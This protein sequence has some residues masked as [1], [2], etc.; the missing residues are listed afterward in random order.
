MN[1]ATSRLN[2]K[3]ML[4][5][6]VGIVSLIGSCAPLGTAAW[7]TWQGN[8]SR[9]L[10]LAAD[11]PLVGVAVDVQAARHA[12]IALRVDL[13]ALDQATVKDT[14]AVPVTVRVRDA[15]GRVL[16]E[17][18]RDTEA[19]GARDGHA[20]IAK[21]GGGHL[22]LQYDFAA[23]M[24]PADGRIV[25]DAMLAGARDDG[26][27]LEKAELI[28]NDGIGDDAVG[29]TCGVF[30][31]LAG[32]IAAVVGVL[33][34]LGNPSS[35]V[36]QSAVDADE[37]GMAMRGAMRGHLLGLLVYPLPFIH[38]LVMSSAWLRGRKTS[39]YVEEHGREALNFQLSILVYLLIAFA[40]SMVLIG[41][42]MLPLV[43]LFQGV[44][45]IEAAVQ[46]RAGHR[47]R[48]PLTFRFL[49]APTAEMLSVASPPSS[50]DQSSCASQKS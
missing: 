1:V 2:R 22:T 17:E 35:S 47:F 30:M 3:A 44:M 27:A 41:L 24:V 34:L 18:T 42:L 26:A 4:A 6:M 11:M 49:R 29:V 19:G 21:A 32:W 31:L 14:H 40:L 43:L 39:A 36:A 16:L 20:R 50:Q 12:R 15:E 33:T 10:P 28:V 25:V 46:A 45:T 5:A 8:P 37:R 38:L 7:H 48:Y 9:V 13:K 23:F